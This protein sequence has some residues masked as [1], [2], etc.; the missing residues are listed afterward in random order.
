MTRTK[1][2]TYSSQIIVQL[3]FSKINSLLSA[4]SILSRS[5]MAYNATDSLDKLTCTEYVD[6][7][8]SPDGFGRFFWTKN[9]SNCLDIQL[10]MFNRGNRNAEF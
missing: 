10:K 5:P 4:T 8:K 3:S 1:A 7:D 2:M 9:D 6:F